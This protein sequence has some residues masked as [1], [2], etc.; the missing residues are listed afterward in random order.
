MTNAPQASASAATTAPDRYAAAT[1]R[2]RDANDVAR[3][4]SGLPGTEGSP[5]AE[6]EK[7]EAWKLHHREMDRAWKG[8]DES[9]MRPMRQFQAS[10]LSSPAIEKS[11][12]FYPFSGPD[13]LMLTVFF[14]K[15]ATYVMVALEPAG[16]CQR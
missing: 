13:A 8:F 14:P 11:L 10:E 5:F 16:T 9:T 3:F 1:P 4:L 2:S 12:A 7:T 6:L 15:N